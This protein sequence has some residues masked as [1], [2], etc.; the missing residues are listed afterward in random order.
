VRSAG[1][2]AIAVLLIMGSAPHERLEG[3]ENFSQFDCA[4]SVS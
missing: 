2:D 4:T 1:L 3:V